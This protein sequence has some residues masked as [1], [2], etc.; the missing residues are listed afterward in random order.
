VIVVAAT[1]TFAVY[2]RGSCRNCRL[3]IERRRLLG[4]LHLDAFFV[5]QIRQEEGKSMLVAAPE[6]RSADAMIYP[7]PELY[8]EAEAASY[9]CFP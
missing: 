5:C 7:I 9:P 2:D 8:R 3:A 4:W 6:G 1:T